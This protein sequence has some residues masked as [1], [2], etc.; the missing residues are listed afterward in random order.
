MTI[1]TIDALVLT[2]MFA[3]SAA[4]QMAGPKFLLARYRRWRFPANTHLIVGVL[5]LLAA[6]FLSNPIT[7]I[8]G[9]ALGVLIAFIT[10]VTLLNHGK[11]GYSLPVMLVMAALIPASLAGPL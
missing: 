3:V 7:R 1:P 6:L 4:I 2:T 11:Y 10:V 8:W 9:V 5:Q